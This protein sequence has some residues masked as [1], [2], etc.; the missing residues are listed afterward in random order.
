MKL[1]LAAGATAAVLLAQQFKF[2]LEHLAA[3]ASNKVELNLG[4]E[5]LQ[6]GLS[7]LSAK[8]PDQAKVKQMVSGLQGVYIRNF[9]FKKTGEY[10]KS[11]LDQIRDQLKAPEWQRIVGVDSS[12]DGEVV[13]VWVRM[14]SGK[15]AGVA[16][17]A[18]DPRELTVVNLVGTVE[19]SA[20]SELGGKFGIPKI[21][22]K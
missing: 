17:L 2:N 10:T 13:E 4:P 18:A 3:K 14:E 8:D 15:M 9:E 1:L 16:I 21:K 22:K 20:L 19:L 11:D 12:T 7:V 5:M 6:L